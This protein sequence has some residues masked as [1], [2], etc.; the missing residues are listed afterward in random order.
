MADFRVDQ[1]AGLRRLF[2]ESHLQVITF[3]AGSEGLGRSVA[4]SNVA[5]VLA[6]LGKE[7]LVLD[8]NAA[9]DDIASSFGQAARYD[10]L[11]VL[12]GERRLADVLIQPMAGLNILPASRAVKKLGGL[13]RVQQ[14]A[15]TGAMQQLERPVDVILVDAST[16]HP[17]GFSPLGLASH[18]TV[19]V[20][21][22]NSASI[23]E[24]YS[25]IKKVSQSFARRHFRILINKVRTVTDA[26]SIFDNIADVAEQRGVAQLEFAGAI[27]SD[28]ALRQAGQ[29]CRPVVAA[30]PESPAARA[31]RQLASDMLHWRQGQNDAGGA[32]QFFQQLLHLS[33][34][35]TPPVVRAG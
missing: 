9:D 13:S 1:A 4:V 17:I 6:R 27:P 18:E 26:R 11:H 24:G 19:V 31:F 20:L 15:F 14:Q 10:L 32:Q 22:A 28:E 21:S 16:R 35:I 3:T 12:N 5:A 2:G 25:L 29:L 23:T 34:R 7:V 8:E 30:M 33:Q